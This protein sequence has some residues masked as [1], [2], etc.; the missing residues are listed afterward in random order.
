MS[1]G[2]GVRA[3]DPRRT[4]TTRLRRGRQRGGPLTAR[5]REI[6]GLLA[7]GM[8]GTDIAA[9]LILSPD[10]VRTHIRNAMA[11]LG[12]STRSQAVVLALQ[13]DDLADEE[14]G[15]GRPSTRLPAA[16]RQR[17]RALPPGPELNRALE[18]MLAGLCSLHDI[19]GGLVLLAEEDGLILRRVAVVTAN[20]ALPLEIPERIALGEGPLGRVALNRRAALLP[21]LSSTPAHSG[22]AL[23]APILANGHLFGVL[24]LATRAS[25][26]TGQGELLVLQALVNR[27]GELLRSG[28]DIDR[29]LETTVQRFGAS[30][31]ATT[32]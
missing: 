18:G 22:A 6:V 2:Q 28:E 27:V 29:R 5:Q 11:K 26:P 25:R 1:R 12:A 17:A 15:E 9:K 4:A 8:S 24:G 10:T 14:R 30:W 32:A 7:E 13:H 21:A 19:D 31:S 16:S 20:G 3:V 23:A